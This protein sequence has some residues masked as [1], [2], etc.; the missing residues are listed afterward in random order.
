MEALLIIAG[1]WFGIWFIGWISEQYKEHVE[2]Q[3]SMTRNQAAMAVLAEHSITAD[4]FQELNN[5]YYHVEQAIPVRLRNNES[6]LITPPFALKQRGSQQCDKCHV[7]YLVRREGKYGPF[8]GCVLYPKC[9]NTKPI[10]WV[11][12]DYKNEQKEKIKKQ[13][14]SDLERA[15]S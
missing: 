2:Y 10:N 3:R 4:T 1:I 15:Y 8:L 12:K 5:H 9:A 11:D 14:M 7:G 6:E 13:F